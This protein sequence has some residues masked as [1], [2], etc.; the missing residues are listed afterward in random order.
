MNDLFCGL[1]CQ[2]LNLSVYIPLTDSV[3]RNGCI[4]ANG[5]SQLINTNSYVKLLVKHYKKDDHVINY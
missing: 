5:F 2:H 3:D 1:F 4:I